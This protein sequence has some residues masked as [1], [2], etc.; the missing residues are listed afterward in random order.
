MEKVGKEPEDE[1]SDREIYAAGEVLDKDFDSPEKVVSAQEEEKANE[2]MTTEE[3]NVKNAMAAV[4][5][6][7]AEEENNNEAKVAEDE[8]PAKKMKAAD[9]EM[10]ILGCSKCRGQ[11]TGC[12]Q[13]KN[14]A[15]CGKWFRR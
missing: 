3:E 2:D 15:F 12:V 9:A 6:K 11:P 5:K 4:K 8:T 10:L 13:C 7:A 1:E 14:P